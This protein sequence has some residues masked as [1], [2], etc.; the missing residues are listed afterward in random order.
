MS[1]RSEINAEILSITAGQILNE[2][3]RFVFMGSLARAAVLGYDIATLSD[4][5]GRRFLDI[6]AL[7]RSGTLTKKYTMLSGLV[8]FRPTESIRPVSAHSHEWGLYDLYQPDSLPI[9]TFSEESFGLHDIHFS[10]RYEDQ[11]IVTPSAAALVGISDIYKYASRM[12][13]HHDQLKALQSVARK[14]PE[15]LHDALGVYDK[16]MMDRYGNGNYIRLRRALFNKM[17]G[18]ALSIQDGI[19]GDIIRIARG[20]NDV[21]EACPELIFENDES[22]SAVQAPEH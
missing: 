7:D 22:I 17:P 8:D 19:L 6:D 16:V 15:D 11:T 4:P 2:K 1:S 9:S 10:K 20:T 21:S 13:K 3:P 18:L 5:S 14:L 12:P